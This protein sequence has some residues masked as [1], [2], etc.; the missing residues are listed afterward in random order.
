MFKCLSVSGFAHS[1]RITRA[2]QVLYCNPGTPRCT[3]AYGWGCADATCKPHT[4]ELP[5][6]LQGGLCHCRE[7]LHLPGPAVAPC[8]A[9]CLQL[10]GISSKP[11]AHRFSWKMDQGNLLAPW[12]EKLEEGTWIST[13]PF[14]P[15]H[16]FLFHIFS[17][18]FICILVKIHSKY[19][20]PKSKF[21]SG[22]MQTLS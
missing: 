8:E 5:R 1:Q 14:L 17:S 13:S 10:M 20:A 6:P 21:Y 22:F 9:S 18:Q 19:S 3:A 11:D 12:R 7:P 4:W 16:F 15:L 2:T